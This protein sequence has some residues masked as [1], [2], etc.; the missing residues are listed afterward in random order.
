M[1]DG[2]TD[3]KIELLVRAV[4]RRVT[5]A[6][7]VRILSKGACGDGRRLNG[8]LRALVKAGVLMRIASAKRG[9]T[10]SYTPKAW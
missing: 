7:L 9:A 1:V 2:L 3:D 6:T 4:G 8:R 5:A 10:G